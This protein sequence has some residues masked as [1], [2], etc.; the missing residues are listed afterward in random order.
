MNQFLRIFF[1]RLLKSPLGGRGESG[2]LAGKLKTGF[3]AID[4]VMVREKFIKTGFKGDETPDQ[5]K[6]GKTN[7]QTKNINGG[8]NFLGFEL[9][10][11]GSNKLGQTNTPYT[12][13]KP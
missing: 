8:K 7:C 3:Q 9:A 6:Y 11:P 12:I 2:I 5:N 13:S 4:V 1:N 10:K